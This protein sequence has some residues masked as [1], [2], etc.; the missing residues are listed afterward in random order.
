MLWVMGG[1]LVGLA[2][3]YYAVRRGGSVVKTVEP[4]EALKLAMLQ[5]SEERYRQLFDS[6]LEG[7]YETFQ[8]GKFRNANPAMAQIFGY[9]SPADLTAFSG[10]QVQALYVNAGRRQEF[11]AA[12]NRDG[13]LR[14]FQS[15]V[16]RNDGAIA[17][18]SEV[19]RMGRDDGTGEVYYQ[20]FVTDITDR[21]RAESDQR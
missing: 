14:N 6:A 9:E 5:N 21:K 3:G 8:N 17:W 16:Q 13:H 18:I 12:I 11:Y 19:V 4:S 1:L 10:A 7:I 20:G 15:Q 2:L